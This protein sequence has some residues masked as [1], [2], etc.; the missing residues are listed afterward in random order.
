MKKRKIH[1]FS[2]FNIFGLFCDFSQFGKKI[3]NLEESKGIVARWSSK[4]LMHPTSYMQTERRN[5]MGLDRAS[6]TLRDS[7]IGWEQKRLIR[8]K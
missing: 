7:L 8:R 2:N 5:I 6:E 1:N 3:K 4:T